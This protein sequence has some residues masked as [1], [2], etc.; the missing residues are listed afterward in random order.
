MWSNEQGPFWRLVGA[1]LGFILCAAALWSASLR[2]IDPHHMGDLGLVSVLPA[3]VYV[4][5]LMLTLSFCV[6]V[7]HRRTPEPIL[8]LHVVLWILMIHGTPALR[9]G[10]LRYSWAWKHVGIVDYIQRHG[11]VDRAI[12]YLNVYHNWPG[13]FALSTFFTELAGFKSALSFAG[14]A[15]VFF[16]LLFL[17]ALLLIFRSCAADRR[18]VWL[19]AWFF[20]L[21][22]WVGQ[23]YFSPQAL[24]YFLHLVILGICLRW[25]SVTTAPSKAAVKDWLVFDP[26]VSLFQRI[27]TRGLSND[28]NDTAP[29][30]ARRA[31]LL[32]TIVLLF[33]VVVSSHQ[34]TPFMTILAVSALVV[35]HRCTAR[36]LPLLMAVLALA[37]I[38]YAA[39]P[40]TGKNFSAIIQSI[41]QANA[42]VDANLIDMS[43]ASVGQKLVAVAGRALTILL[44]SLAVAGGIR[45]LRWGHWDLPFVLLAVT[46][47]LML[48][49][50]SYGGEILFRV[51]FFALPFMAFFAAALVFPHSAIATS[52]RTVVLAIVLS[53]TLQIGFCFAYYGKDRAY[54]FTENEVEA[55]QYLSTVA[56]NGALIVEG[57]TNY[58]S[59][60]QHY[61]R[62]TYW[63]LVVWPRAH[64]EPTINQYR[65][66]DIRAAMADPTFTAAYLIITRSQEAELAMLGGGSFDRLERDLMQSGAFKIIF[67]N[68]DATIYTLKDGSRGSR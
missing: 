29:L 20:L 42:N 65:A 45:R 5:L 32:A 10:T 3:A 13:F 14:W 23:D 49:G 22:N 31:A 44:W 41:G 37:W 2:G 43:Q 63:P 25:F 47:F 35:F 54:Y 39:A 64:G 59:R 19:G 26:L 62:Y 48:V 67:A 17:G 28:T 55:G 15:P 4:A 18:L 8:L 51:Y 30:R 53:V 33:A 52:Q 38:V 9:Y 6:S 46:P 27:V 1:P 60:F 61:E 24:S 21:T 57:S 56:P 58:P 40:F 16:N 12:P 34:L 66:D 11:S 50:N 36:G 7:C 68:T